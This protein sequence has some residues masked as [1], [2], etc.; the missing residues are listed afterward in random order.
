MLTSRRGPPWL[1]GPALGSQPASRVQ[2]RERVR[3]RFVVHPV[4]QSKQGGGCRHQGH[5]RSIRSRHR[6][7]LQYTVPRYRWHLNP[8]K[9]KL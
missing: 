1:L 6:G 8:I 2:G 9:I 4:Q 5:H 3:L 7:L